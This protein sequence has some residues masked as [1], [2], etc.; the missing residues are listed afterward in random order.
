[1]NNLSSQIR[2]A[3]K[4]AVKE[5]SLGVEQIFASMDTDGNNLVDKQ[6]LM[7]G[8]EQL[9]IACSKEEINLIWPMFDKDGDGEYYDTFF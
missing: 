2:A 1:M 3:I 7:N 9:K 8:F 6:E 5:G 4:R